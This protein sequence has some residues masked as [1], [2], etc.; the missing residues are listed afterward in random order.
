MQQAS[1]GVAMPISRFEIPVWDQPAVTFC[2]AAPT[3]EM[4]GCCGP[5]CVNQ[6]CLRHGGLKRIMT[7]D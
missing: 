6:I 5:S 2:C 4:Q 7:V 3:C 1:A